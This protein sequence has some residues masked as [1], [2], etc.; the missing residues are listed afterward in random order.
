MERRGYPGELKI[1][2]YLR[3]AIGLVKHAAASDAPGKY[4][5]A[6]VP[7]FFFLVCFL[8]P[9]FCH[10]TAENA[11][12]RRLPVYQ[13]C[14]VFAP[15]PSIP[16]RASSHHLCHTYILYLYLYFYFVFCISATQNARRGISLTPQ[17]AYCHAGCYRMQSGIGLQMPGELVSRDEA[18]VRKPQTRATVENCSHVACAR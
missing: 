13:N 4:C 9:L 15:H 10:K 1:L 18:R 11:P 17:A 12:A 2:T 7:G 16:C 6:A 14:C 3:N 8:Q 5:G